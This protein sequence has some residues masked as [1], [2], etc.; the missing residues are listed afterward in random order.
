[1]VWAKCDLLLLVP[2]I[3][4]SPQA[5]ELSHCCIYKLFPW[6]VLQVLPVLCNLKT[7]ILTG[8]RWFLVI[9]LSWC[10]N[11]KG[12]LLPSRLCWA[13]TW[14]QLLP[15]VIFFVDLFLG[16]MCWYFWKISHLLIPHVVSVSLL[17]LCRNCGW[18]TS[19]WKKL[20]CKT[21]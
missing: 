1:M 8:A 4:K 14:H 20:T 19:V 2:F 10:C 15:C 17:G 7:W 18:D 12:F 21:K 9:T 16:Y 6:A 3:P 5:Q 13:A 11:Q